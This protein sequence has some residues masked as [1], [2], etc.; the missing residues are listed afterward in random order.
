MLLGYV[1]AIKMAWH[2]RDSA[3]LFRH[4]WLA[5]HIPDPQAR[6]NHQACQVRSIGFIG[7]PY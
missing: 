3:R 2:E 4:S 6:D 7:G 1:G 5:R